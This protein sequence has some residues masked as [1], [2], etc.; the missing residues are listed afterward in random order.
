MHDERLDG[1]ICYYYIAGKF[2]GCGEFG[3]SFMI[4]ETKT[5]QISNCN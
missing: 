2:G 4:H 3:K 5:I 1:E